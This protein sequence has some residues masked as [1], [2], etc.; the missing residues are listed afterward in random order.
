[1]TIYSQLQ[2]NV[3]E[4]RHAQDCFWDDLQK[5]IT[6]FQSEMLIHFGVAGKTLRFEN[7]DETPVILFGSYDGEDVVPL[8][9][10]LL[11]KDEENLLL[12]FSVQVF[13]SKLGSEMV[14]SGLIFNCS[15]TK[16]DDNYIINVSGNDIACP[17]DQLNLDFV[18]V[19]D[20]IEKRLYEYHDKTKF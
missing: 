19:F 3:T 14:D 16:K 6:P 20:Y 8:V 7:D 2:Q 13:L 1:M 11:D 9:P 17:L 15:I 10:S 5:K 4:F 18:K 12:E